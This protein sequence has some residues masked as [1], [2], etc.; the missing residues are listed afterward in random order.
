MAKHWVVQAIAL[1]K[2]SRDPVP[3]EIN[4]LDWKLSLSG[5][6]E[7]LIEHLI[8]FSNCPHGGSLYAPRQFADMAQA[9]RV[10]ACYQHAVLQ[11]FS[12]QTLTNT[13]L[14]TRFKVSERQRNQITNLIADAVAAGRIKRKDSTSGNKFAEYVPYWA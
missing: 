7:R 4:E 12:S 8:A 5:N 3:H 6:K 9:E 14:R 1:L 2:S 13:T 11:Y 10:E